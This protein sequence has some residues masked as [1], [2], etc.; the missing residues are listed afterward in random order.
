MFEAKCHCGN[1]TLETKEI[2]ETITSCNCSICHRIGALWGYFLEGNVEIKIKTT[3]NIYMF[4]K[5]LRTYHSCPVCGCT[6]HYTQNRD[7]G[8]KR[9]AINTRM[10][11]P[12]IIK[13]IQVKYFD[14]AHT[15]KYIA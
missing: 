13:P 14:G 5:K 11:N 15:F 12:E 6:T 3:K 1:I 7:D 9:V 10:A 4:G 8:T 2:P